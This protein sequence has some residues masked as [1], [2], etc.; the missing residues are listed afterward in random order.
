[1][2]ATRKT[3]TPTQALTQ[4]TEATRE[5]EVPK[6]PADAALHLGIDYANTTFGSA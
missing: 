2:T 1:M 3:P 6:V 5:A 4:T